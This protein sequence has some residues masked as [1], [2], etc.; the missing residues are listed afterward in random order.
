MLMLT[1]YARLSNELDDLIFLSSSLSITSSSRQSP[2]LYD[3]R[4]FDFL[5]NV[6]P[7]GVCL[8]TKNNRSIGVGRDPHFPQG[9]QYPAI[10]PFLD[11]R[12]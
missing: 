2:T 7:R 4:R 3:C 10:L 6:G 1:T 5:R 11:E 9:L 8:T 12:G